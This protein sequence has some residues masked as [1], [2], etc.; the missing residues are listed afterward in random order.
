MSAVALGAMAIVVAITVTTSG[1]SLY[2][3]FIRA[4]VVTMDFIRNFVI[5][6]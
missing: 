5:G 6:V 3:I 1:E 4:T 2:V